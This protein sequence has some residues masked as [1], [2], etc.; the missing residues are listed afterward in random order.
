MRS[1]S[2]CQ[3]RP[4]SV[5]RVGSGLFY[6]FIG[7]RLFSLKKEEE[8]EKPGHRSLRYSLVVLNANLLLLRGYDRRCSRR[9]IL[10]YIATADV[11]VR[12]LATLQPILATYV[13]VGPRAQHRAR[14]ESAGSQRG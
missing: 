3:R 10:A 1:R 2:P 5:K 6:G 4:E 12:A 7:L 9:D 11:Q 13:L 14:P 8:E